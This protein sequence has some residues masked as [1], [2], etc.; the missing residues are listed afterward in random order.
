MK[1]GKRIYT[2]LVDRSRALTPHRLYARLNGPTIIAN[3][4]PKGGTHVL[5]RC[6]SLF[7]DLSYSFIHYTKGNPDLLAIQNVLGKT[8]KGRFSAAHLWWNEPCAK[9]FAQKAVRSIVMVRDPRDL[10]ISGIHYILKRKSHHW[11]RYFNSLPNFDAQIL[12]YIEGVDA[13]HSD[14]SMALNN[15]Q[16]SFDHYLAWDQE[17]F[18]ILI[19]FED[20]IGPNGG[21]EAS[22]QLEQVRKISQHLNFDLS[23]HVLQRIAHNTFYS[24]SVTFRK[25]SAG[26]WQKHFNDEHKDA[27]KNTAPELLTSLGYEQDVN[28]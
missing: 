14:A 12:A 26:E 24:K 5:T 1:V 11:H 28:W 27:F 17:P 15:I 21:G 25:G 7:P 16:S 20:L 4:I 13:S 22:L 3:S 18:N 23:D 8:G 19:K 10:I 9:L 6:L 2:R